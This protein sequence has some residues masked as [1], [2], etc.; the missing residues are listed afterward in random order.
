MVVHGDLAFYVGAQTALSSL[1]FGGLMLMAGRCSVV[2]EFRC[3]DDHGL[4]N[5]PI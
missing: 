4:V 3:E 2:K 5:K 1:F